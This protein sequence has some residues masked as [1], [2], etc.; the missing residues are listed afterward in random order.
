MSDRRADELERLLVEALPT[1]ALIEDG[2][3]ADRI[4]A[5]L[6]R[7]PDPAPLEPRR[8]GPPPREVLL[9]AMNANRWNRGAAAL[10]LGASRR[11]LYRWLRV[12][13]VQ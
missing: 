13:G 11:T 9:E 4:R 7:P 10:S 12:R 1:L 2:R 5:A 8:R 3:L 6:N